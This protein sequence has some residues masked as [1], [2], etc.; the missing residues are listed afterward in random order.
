MER[1]LL[2]EKEKF[3]RLQEKLEQER[4]WRRRETEE[5]ERRKE[6]LLRVREEI[7]ALEAE[8]EKE[9]GIRLRLQRET[10]DLK[11]DLQAAAVRRRE[12]E[13]QVDRLE[14]QVRVYR[15]EIRTLREDNQKLSRRHD[16]SSW[17]AKS[18]YTALEVALEE[19]RR[20]LEALRRRFR[21]GREQES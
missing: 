20:E 16:E 10:A 17:V 7:R 13:G 5:E 14:A 18:A 15:E 2:I 12:L 4:S 9:H 6:A 11:R 21:V 3:E 19:T 8:A 1:A